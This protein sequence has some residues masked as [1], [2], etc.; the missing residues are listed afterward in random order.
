M[1]ILIVEDDSKL[2]QVL[3]FALEKHGHRTTLAANGT[4]G[5]EIARNHQFESIILDAMLPEMDGYTVAQIGRASC[6]ERVCMLV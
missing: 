2:A 5:Y 4:D 3:R 6:R 1:R